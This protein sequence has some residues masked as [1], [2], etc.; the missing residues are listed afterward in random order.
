MAEPSTAPLADRQPSGP[1][2][3]AD[4]AA[5]VE[6]VGE[7]L[8]AE[9]CDEALELLHR[10]VAECPERH[11]VHALLALTYRQLGRLAEAVDSLDEAIARAP[12]ALEL[13]FE[14]AALLSGLGRHDEAIL[15]FEY[16]LTRLPDHPTAHRLRITALVAAGRRA[17]AAEAMAEALARLPQSL[18]LRTLEGTTL[19]AAGK[20]S[21]ALAV[22][23]AVLATQ[24]DYLPALYEA[25]TTL[26]LLGRPQEAMACLDKALEQKGDFVP[27]LMAIGMAEADLGMNEAAFAALDRAFA[28]EP[29]NAEVVHKRAMMLKRLNRDDEALAGF[30]RVLE[31]DPRAYAA[32]ANIAAI[33]FNRGRFAQAMAHHEKAHALCPDDA[34]LFS[35]ILFTQL[36]DPAA[37]PAD[38]AR[39]HRR[40]DAL[41]GRPASRYTHW[42]N[43][44]DPDRKLRIG[45]LSSEF[46]ALAT[47]TLIFPFLEGIDRTAFELHGFHHAARQDA[48]TE[49]FARL[50]DSLSIVVGLDDEDLAA[51]IRAKE[52]DILIELTGH[53]NLNRLACMALKPAPVQANW[54]GY[55]FSTGLSAIDYSIM[56]RVA[57]RPGEEAFFSET[58]VRLEGSRHCAEPP[59]AAPPVTPPPVLERGW[60]TFG[61]FNRISKVNDA[62]LACW[63]RILA[64]VPESR[65]MLKDSPL[66]TP[67][68]EV[69][70]LQRTL[71]EHGIDPQRLVLRGRSDKMT[72][73]A[74][75]GEVDIALDPFPFS[76]A[77]TTIDALWMGLPVVTLPGAQPVSRQT[78]T[79]LVALGR[80]AWVARDVEDYGR[81]ATDLAADPR[82]LAEW[83]AGQR[84]AMRASR[85]C[86]KHL[87]A[88]DLERAL[89]W[90]W[91]SY[92]DS[93]RT[94]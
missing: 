54:L 46:C 69:D 64:A 5:L 29:K 62:V 61:S 92:V 13:R 41:Y 47:N 86:D 67:G 18:E 2:V 9:R 83:R 36:H 28:L 68:P 57:V 27:A 24:P 59:A 49:R 63:C 38:L 1:S 50:L 40:Y 89:R 4:D 77:A 48:V 81:I 30:E 35:N 76:G 80:E 65:L 85:L 26:Q 73:L 42:P 11:V 31:L 79:F 70:R 20:L 94:P 52:I 58:V 3:P 32:H 25:G 91:R 60:I 34:R 8:A 56:D 19:R 71:A 6:T 45:L 21:R 17:A 72:F 39:S 14:R 82:R 15:A 51:A 93:R 12:E 22:Q 90:M 53:T 84:Q 43:D 44:L 78:Q 87:A 55:P 66:A 33:S 10:A 7:R 88:R 75:H 16:L 74:E 23:Q 37:T